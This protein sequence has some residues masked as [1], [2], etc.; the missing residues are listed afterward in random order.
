V[1]LSAA[2]QARITALKKVTRGI[3]ADNEAGKAVLQS[4]KR[5]VEDVSVDKMNKFEKRD[6]DARRW[7]EVVGRKPPQQKHHR[8]VAQVR[9]HE[10]ISRICLLFFSYESFYFGI[11]L[12]FWIFDIGFIF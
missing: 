9:L 3:M 4:L 12:E 5:E 11:I 1:S 8:R 7:E 2:T 6:Y 10:D